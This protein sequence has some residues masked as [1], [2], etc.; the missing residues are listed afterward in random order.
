MPIGKARLKI[1]VLESHWDLPGANDLFKGIHGSP[2]LK[3]E[4][5]FQC[6]L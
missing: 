3:Y 6:P 2:H 1:T 4:K 5:H